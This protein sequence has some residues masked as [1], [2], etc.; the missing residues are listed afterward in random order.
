MLTKEPSQREP[1]PSRRAGATTLCLI[2][3]GLLIA[4]ALTPKPPAFN[5][6]WDG[7]F[8]AVREI[9]FGSS[10]LPMHGICGS[11]SDYSWPGFNYSCEFDVGVQCAHGLRCLPE[12]Y[13][14]SCQR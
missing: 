12:E 10:E 4:A 9:F 2:L 1:K 11:C 13:E 7:W 8:P 3:A 5:A 6:W 14:M